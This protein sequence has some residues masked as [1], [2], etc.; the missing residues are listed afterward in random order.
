MTGKV[1]ICTLCA[2]NAQGSA[3]YLKQRLSAYTAVS[4]INDF[5]DTAS[6]AEGVKNCIADGGAVVA[7]VPVSDFLK[8]KLRLIKSVS[9]KIVRSSAIVSAMG[10][11]APAD[12]KESDLQAAIPEKSTAV[13]SQN[14]LYSGFTKEHDNGVLIFLPLEDGLLAQMLPSVLGCIPAIAPDPSAA[15]SGEKRGVAKL[16]SYIENVVSS[17][18][19]VAISPVGCAK[20]LI[21][22]IST[23]QGCEDAF[24]V[25]SALRDRLQG[26]ST[27]DYIAQCAKISKENA[28]ADLGISISNIYSGKADG[29]NFVTVCVADSERAKAAKVYANPGE[30]KKHLIV[31]AVIKLCEMLGEFSVTGLVNPNLPEKQPKSRAK[32][33]KI[34]MIIAA[35][36]LFAAIIICAVL[37]IKMGNGNSNSA[38]TYADSN[39]YYQGESNTLDNNSDSYEYD[40]YGGSYLDPLGG[41]MNA[42]VIIPESTSALSTASQIIT[43]ASTTA[44]KIT[45][46]TKKIITTVAKITTTI[47]TTLAT[48]KPTTTKPT[49]TKATTTKPTTTT[50]TTTKITTT[51][52]PTT[53]VPTTTKGGT[54]LSAESTGTFV[55]KVYGFGHGVGMSQDG[56]IQMAK[57][58]STYDE[59]LTHYFTGTT[60]V[61]DSATPLTIKYGEKDIPIVE[62][63]CK[64]TKRE[65]GAGAPTEAL[66]AQIVSA[67]TYAKWYNFD[68]AKSRHAYDESYAYEGTN[69]HKACLEVLGMAAD[70]DTPKAPYVDYNGKPA[71]T[72]YFASAAGKT[73]SAS[74]VW[75]STDSQ[76]PYL[77]GGVSSPEKVDTTTVEIS[78]AD[79]KKLIEEYAKSNGKEIVL[80]ENPAGWLEIVEHD[81]AYGADIGYVT[82]M[83]VGNY[84]MKGNGFRSYVMDFKLRS[85]CFT[86]KYI[87]ASEQTT[88]KS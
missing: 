6:F 66:K 71:F 63:L 61:T 48:T 73:A 38:E 19:T 9:S 77:K 21:S 24:I 16:K 80:S 8:A 64:T 86:F 44:N 42:A 7:A 13:L 81:S 31:A 62:Y 49:T 37:A 87:P 47:K 54:T 30:D 5:G 67:Y 79:M 56:A 60:I 43:T 83:R 68:V 25:D 41:E 53:T 78:A 52:K 46:T 11:N 35:V 12:P 69:L 2:Q 39:P 10:Q 14:G 57:D 82:T 3:D 84:Q 18:K 28:K 88:E 72:C 58:G 74:S 15:S 65:I 70:T 29:E 32:I 55:F 36:A 22:A 40:Y 75:G 20:P 85:H 51:Q 59:I 33:S 17:G 34:P 23:V 1:S 76:Y 50:T 27:E 26:E 4:E 45:T